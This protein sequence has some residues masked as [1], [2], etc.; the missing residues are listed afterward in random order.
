MSFFKDFAKAVIN[1]IGATTELVTGS[2]LLGK[3]SNPTGEFSGRAFGALPLAARLSGSLTK[4]VKE[5][6]EW[7]EAEKKRKAEK[8]DKELFEKTDPRQALGSAGAFSTMGETQRRRMRNMQK[9]L[10]NSTS[11]IPSLLGDQ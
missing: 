1:P 3:I 9:S 5:A 7:Q 4:S 11:T 6:V 8:A 2:S 10:L